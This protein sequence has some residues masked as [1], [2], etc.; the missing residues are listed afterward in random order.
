MTTARNIFAR[1][2]TLAAM[3][4][5]VM[6]FMRLFTSDGEMTSA[7]KE[8]PSTSMAKTW[9]GEINYA[10]AYLALTPYAKRQEKG[11]SSKFDPLDEYWGLPRSDGVENVS[12][13]CGACHSLQ[14]VMQ[15]RQTH[16]GWDYLL[17]WMVKKQGM[18]ELT[19]DTRDEILD[20]LT[21]EFG[22]E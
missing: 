4:I 18:A 15:Q 19:P 22:H 12:A 9:S 6:L 7:Q 16:E 1:A 5:V 11:H 3:V 13:Y 2:L 17:T 20:Y 21:R 8:S 14:I 10:P